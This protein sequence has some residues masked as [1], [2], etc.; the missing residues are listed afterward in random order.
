MDSSKRLHHHIVLA[1]ALAVVWLALSGH[2]G[3]L[4]LWLGAASVA[5]S[6]WMASR[7]SAFDEELHPAQ[8]ET[9]PTIMYIG[10]LTREVMLSALDVS[11]RV[12]DPGLP[13]SPVAIKVPLTQRTELGRVVY[14]N[15]ITLTPGTVSI[16]LSE[17]SVTVH[18]LSQEGADSLAAG[19]MDRRVSTLERGH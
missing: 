13:I 18:A 14:A 12:L 11:K 15:S 9:L 1:I 17:H 6:V 10:W 2:F 19:E 5:F 3:S 16:D 7:M 4:L 8:F